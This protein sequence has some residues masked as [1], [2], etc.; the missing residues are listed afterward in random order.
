MHA[1]RTDFSLR[2]AKRSPKFSHLLLVV[3]CLGVI[4]LVPA[5]KTEAVSFD[6]CPTLTGDG[7]QSN[8]W[9]L[10]T[11]DDFGCFEPGFAMFPAGGGFD[12]YVALAN[13]L[14]WESNYPLFT[15]QNQGNLHFDGRGLSI[16][17][18]N[19]INSPG[20]FNGTYGAQIS[21]L[22]VRADNSTLA[23][24][25]GWVSGSDTGSTFTS[26]ASN[27][28]I[29]DGGGGIVGEAVGT[30]INRSFSTGTVGSTGGGIVGANS[31]NSVVSNSFSNGL[32]SMGGGGIVGGYSDHAVV[33]NSFST[34]VID[35]FGGGI[36]GFGSNEPTV[37]NSYS[38]GIALGQDSEIIGDGTYLPVVF[39]STGFSSGWSDV[40]ANSTLTSLGN[41]WR[42]C[43]INVPYFVGAFYPSDNC[44]TIR[45]SQIVFSANSTTSANLI[46]PADN[47]FSLVNR[48]QSVPFSFVE[49]IGETARVAMGGV[50]CSSSAP[51]RLHDLAQTADGSRRDITIE[52]AGTVS[53]RRYDAWSGWSSDVQ[54]FSVAPVVL[55]PVN[56]DIAESG[57]TSTGLGSAINVKSRELTVKRGKSVTRSKLLKWYQVSV[58]RNSSV[59]LRIAG[60][61]RKYCTLVG[62][63][64]KGAKIGRCKVSVRIIPKV[65]R[66]KTKTL[67]ITVVR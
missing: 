57:P 8:P 39:N 18:K 27:G 15:A 48:G 22:T 16:T 21:N 37:V 66:A 2:L 55:P 54:R 32:V 31:V 3:A 36:I 28:P 23:D 26:V 34:G 25:A 6:Q 40:V 17:I 50:T 19:V 62:S 29:S 5:S 63:N 7:S 61:S 42:T 11:D 44:G 49:I 60:P 65:G 53:I 33:S 51:C 67:A 12:S 47:T 52:T 43:A 64:V 35:S 45:D 24:G 38:T 41:V 1:T 59:S 30:A 14:T 46:A 9:V 13:D 20:V 58:P 56:Q 4:P 10:W